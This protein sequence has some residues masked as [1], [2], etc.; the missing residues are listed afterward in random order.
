M[1]SNG[2]FVAFAIITCLAGLV[3]SAGDDK[4]SFIFPPNSTVTN[5]TL[6]TPVIA[7]I[8]SVHWN[9]DITVEYTTPDTVKAV[10]LSQLCYDSLSDTNSS[11]EEYTGSSFSSTGICE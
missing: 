8:G 11:S 5:F 4:S 9:D 3:I 7:K 6:H 2:H 10:W 1:G